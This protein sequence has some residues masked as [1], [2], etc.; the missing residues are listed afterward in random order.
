[1][2]HVSGKKLR[3]CKTRLL[4]TLHTSKIH[5]CKW[6]PRYGSTTAETRQEAFAKHKAVGKLAHPALETLSALASI[7]APGALPA[8]MS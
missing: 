7:L 4:R 2:V 6:S 8:S 5:A 1:M 3:D